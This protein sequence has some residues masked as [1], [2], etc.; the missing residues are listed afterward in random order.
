MSNDADVVVIGSGGLGAATAFYLVK[1]GV[2]NVALVDRHDIGSQTSPR[3]AG[4][5]SYVRKSDLMIHLIKRAGQTI[6]HFAQEIG[7]PLQWVQSGSLKVARRPQ[8]AKV[9]Q[10]DSARA[11]RHGLDIEQISAD[12]AIHDYIHELH[13]FDE[14]WSGP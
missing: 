1:R 3:A 13:G 8:D 10:S 5:V 9:L 12:E 4:M 2:R 11:Q 7:Q 6:K 14:F